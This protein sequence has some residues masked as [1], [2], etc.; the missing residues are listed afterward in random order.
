M[1]LPSL[2]SCLETFDKV[3]FAKHV[4][5]TIVTASMFEYMLRYYE[6]FE[7]AHFIAHRKL[8]YG[9]DLLSS[10]QPPSRDSLVFHLLGRVP[11]LLTFPRSYA[12]NSGS[13]ST[14]E[15][16]CMVEQGLIVK[17]YL[18]KGIVK[19]WT[20]ELL[21]ECQKHYPEH[22]GKLLQLKETGRSSQQ[23]F[24]FLRG[25]SNE[26]QGPLTNSAC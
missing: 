3:F 1:A 2:R 19:P 26:I 11:T 16:E 6:P 14:R 24:G 7:Y 22:C 25:L 12:V 23:W 4:V 18:E 9:E 10:I 15:L 13:S 5:P 17:L 21:G 20:K 8:L